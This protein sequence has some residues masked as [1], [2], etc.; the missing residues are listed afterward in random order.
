MLRVSTSAVVMPAIT[1]PSFSRRTA[2]GSCC[3]SSNTASRTSLSLARTHSN[4]AS[5]FFI[6]RP[7]HL[8]ELPAY[9]LRE[10]ASLGDCLLRHPLDQLH[11]GSKRYPFRHPAS[12]A[13]FRLPLAANRRRRARARQ[14]RA[15]G[16]LERSRLHAP[17]GAE[18]RSPQ[19]REH[20]ARHA[21]VERAPAFASR[22]NDNGRGLSQKGYGPGVTLP[23]P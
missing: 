8:F 12:L 10:R 13:R 14:P 11:G 23:E 7:F 19:P 15:A 20:P 2:S 1:S 21:G 18:V 17:A 9:P 16:Q 3:R 6:G 22:R 5:S 4:V